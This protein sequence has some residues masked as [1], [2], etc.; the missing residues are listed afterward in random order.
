MIS[1][2]KVMNYS[3]LGLFNYYNISLSRFSIQRS[4][5]IEKKSKI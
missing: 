4:W 1:N 3:V 5:K 2:E